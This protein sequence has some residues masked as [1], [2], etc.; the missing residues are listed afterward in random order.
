MDS[1]SFVQGTTNNDNRGIAL[2]YT[3]DSDSL[4][5]N[6]KWHKTI[7]IEIKNLAQK[8]STVLLFDSKK[9]MPN[10]SQSGIQYPSWYDEH[11]VCG[12]WIYS[13][14]DY[15]FCWGGV[16]SDGNFKNCI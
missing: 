1:V 11:L 4:W 2:A 16:S 8:Y 13:N 9:N 12:Y 10:V 3:E 14:G 15:K 7:K 5:N 6:S